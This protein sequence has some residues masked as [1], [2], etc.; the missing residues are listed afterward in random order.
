MAANLQQPIVCPPAHN[1]EGCHLIIEFTTGWL[2]GTIT[3]WDGREHTPSLGFGHYLSTC[4][5]LSVFVL[6]FDRTLVGRIIDNPRHLSWGSQ[7][8]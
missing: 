8:G 1:S 6:P 3:C 5:V 7:E 2:L 4:E